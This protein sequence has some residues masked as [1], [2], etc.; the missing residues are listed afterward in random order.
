MG[1]QFVMGAAGRPDSWFGAGGKAYQ[2]EADLFGQVPIA[3]LESRQEYHK[4][5]LE[6]ILQYVIDQAVLADVL[7]AAKAAAGFTVTMP[8]IS[9]KDLAKM[10]NGIPQLATALAVA[11]SNKWVSR[12][13]AT[14]IFAFCCSYLGYEVDPEK[15]IEEALKATPDNEVDYEKMA[16]GES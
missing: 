13:T 5:N 2:T 6:M 10:V 12:D 14:R 11:V 15:E 8:E 16:R 1:K 3:D 7:P 4:F 9:K